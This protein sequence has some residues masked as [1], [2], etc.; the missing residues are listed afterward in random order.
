MWGALMLNVQNINV[1]I[2][3][4]MLLLNIYVLVIM[5]FYLQPNATLIEKMTIEIVEKVR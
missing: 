4:F 2:M 3:L 5:V 1:K